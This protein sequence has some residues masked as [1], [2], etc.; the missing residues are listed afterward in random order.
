MAQREPL[1]YCVVEF[2]QASGQPS[3]GWTD[4]IFDTPEEA[5]R[6]AEAARNALGLLRRER[7]AVAVLTLI[8]DPRE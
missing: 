6:D 3:F 1:G 7:Y 2:N 4:E 5:H 8:E